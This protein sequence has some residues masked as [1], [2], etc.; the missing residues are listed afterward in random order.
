[1]QLL[2]PYRSDVFFLSFLDVLSYSFLD[3]YLILLNKGLYPLLRQLLR[4]GSS[5][6]LSSSYIASFNA[7]SISVI[8]SLTSSNPTE[9]LNKPLVIPRSALIS[10]GIAA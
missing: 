9:S 3:K 5:T 2:L 10:S 6:H 4:Y 1:H 8:N 7:Q